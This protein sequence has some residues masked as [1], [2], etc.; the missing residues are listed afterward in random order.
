MI[1]VG[2]ALIFFVGFCF[3]VELALARPAWHAALAGLAP[4]KELLRDAGMIW[5]AAG[6][7]GAT[8]MPHNL[9]LHSALVKEHAPQRVANGGAEPAFERLRV[10]AAEP[11]G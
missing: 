6:I 7:L 1:L 3:V 9:Y 10:E 4:P 5:L 2:P 11:V 8:V